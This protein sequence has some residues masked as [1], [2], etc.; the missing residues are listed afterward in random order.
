MNKL[1][2]IRNIFCQYDT[3]SFTLKAIYYLSLEL[4]INQPKTTKKEQKC[5]FF[6]IEIRPFFYNKYEWF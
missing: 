6:F 1:V 4:K 5:A 3:H 2:N